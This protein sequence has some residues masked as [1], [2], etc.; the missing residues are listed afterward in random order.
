MSGP[1]GPGVREFIRADACGRP[2]HLAMTGRYPPAPRA[3]GGPVGDRPVRHNARPLVA[4]CELVHRTW[5]VP[6]HLVKET[7]NPTLWWAV[8]LRTRVAAPGRRP[9]SPRVVAAR[10]RRSAAVSKLARL[11][12]ASAGTSQFATFQNRGTQRVLSASI[13]PGPNS[14]GG[15]RGNPAFLSRFQF[16]Y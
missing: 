15:M 8:A 7:R 9:L 12:E 16:F 6:Q 11:R 5:A 10:G 1:S 2:A 3:G 13:R 4:P 14:A